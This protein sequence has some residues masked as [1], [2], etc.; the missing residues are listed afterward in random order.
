[1]TVKVYYFAMLREQAGRDEER[2][3][4]NAAT[5]HALYRELAEAYRLSVPVT[6]L[7]AAVNDAFVGMDAELRD[8]DAVTFIPPVA[9]G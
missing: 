3:E 5:V 7:R 1:M 8:G 9:G 2:R 6:A 4:T